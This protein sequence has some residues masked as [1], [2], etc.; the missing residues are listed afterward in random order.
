MDN[1][2]GRPIPAYLLAIYESSNFPRRGL[3][4]HQFLEYSHVVYKLA[5]A[6]GREHLDYEEWLEGFEWN[7]AEQRVR[8]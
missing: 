8:A 6:G 4:L 2:S 1:T 7:E 3:S 5:P